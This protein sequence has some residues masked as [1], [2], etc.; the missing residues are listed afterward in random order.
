MRVAIYARYSTNM[1]R[2]AVDMLL[3]K[4]KRKGGSR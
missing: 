4:Y 2:E 3:A 1:Q